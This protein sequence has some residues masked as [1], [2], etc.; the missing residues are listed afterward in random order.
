MLTHLI[1]AIVIAQAPI[2]GTRIQLNGQS[3]SGRWL[4]RSGEIFVESKW[5]VSGLG[6]NLFEPPA[7]PQRLKWFSSPFFLPLF[8]PS[9]VDRYVSLSP[10]RSSWRIGSVGNTLQIITP[11]VKIQ[12]LR[13][14]AELSRVVVELSDATPYQWRLENGR[15]TVIIFGEPNPAVSSRKIPGISLRT[16]GRQ[17][18]ISIDNKVTKVDTQDQ[19]KRLVLDFPPKVPVP[20]MANKPT[21]APNPN[22]KPNTSPNSNPNSNPSNKPNTNPNNK[23]SNKP[24]SVPVNPAPIQ[25]IDRVITLPNNPTKF[26]VKALSIDL[27]R[28]SM[29]PIWGN[30]AGVQGTNSL[31]EIAQLSQATAA[32]NGGFFNRDRR[33]PVGAIRRDGMWWSGSALTRGTVAWNDQ[34]QV[35]IDRLTYTEELSINAQKVSLTNL[36]SGFVQKGIARYTS[37]WG[38]NYITITDNEILILVQNEQV[39]GQFQGSLAGQSQLP[40]PK[41]GYLL[42]LR[43][44]PE[45]ITSLSIGTRV[46]VSGQITNPQFQ[47]FPHL[48]SAGPLLLKDGQIVLNIPAESFSSAFAEQTAAR[49]VIATTKNPKQILLVTIN[50]MPDHGL[51]TL[52]QTA[53]ILQQLGAVSALNLDGGSSTGLYYQ[54]KLLNRENSPTVHSALGIFGK[55]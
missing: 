24:S 5:A 33:L 19:P 40:I 46:T 3:L 35:F 31:V 15:T 42:V 20:P 39:T 49:S 22:S 45:Q 17:T 48:L 29:R 28:V 34:G 26:A 32:I 30:P 11:P 47:N 1:T 13:A 2:Q 12:S 14:T 44:V 54:G 41:D 50:A 37:T 7:S 38:E 43:G 8:S 23:P 36:N 10:W 52:T 21:T 9:P 27:G 51:P 16:Q 53:L 55:P 25:I 6:F 4:N 18:I